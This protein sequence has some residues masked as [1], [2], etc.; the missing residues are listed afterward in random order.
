MAEHLSRVVMVFYIVCADALS[1]TSQPDDVP[2]PKDYDS[3]E[4]VVPTAT[5][6]RER[7]SFSRGV[8]GKED[9]PT[10]LLQ[11]GHAVVLNAAEAHSHISKGGHRMGEL[12]G[13]RTMVYEGLSAFAATACAAVNETGGRAVIV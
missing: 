11:V 13:S 9:S 4:A 1:R 8:H 7:Q 3:V 12:A 2:A 5:S 6:R 10:S